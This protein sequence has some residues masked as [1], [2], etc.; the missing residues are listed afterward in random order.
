MR[1]SSP[2]SFRPFWQELVDAEIDAHV[3]QRTDGRWYWRYCR[4]AL[5]GLLGELSAPVPAPPAQPRPC[6]SSAPAAPERVG[7]R[8]LAWRVVSRHGHCHLFSANGATRRQTVTAT[9]NTRACSVH[10]SAWSRYWWTA[11]H[12][13]LIGRARG[14]RI[15]HGSTRTGMAP[16]LDR[17]A[18]SGAARQSGER[19]RRRS[20]RGCGTGRIRRR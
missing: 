18:R 15:R 1:R 16:R 5:I 10:H 7:D 14:A 8:L 4:S 2:G 12:G 6:W 9:A 13:A 19:V 17:P 20:A 3:E 11:K